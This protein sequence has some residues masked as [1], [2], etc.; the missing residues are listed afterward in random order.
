MDPKLRVLV[1]DDTIVY[2]KIVSSVLAEMPN[3]EVVGT[4]ANG[5]IAL[6][7]IAQ[8]RPDLLLLDLEMPELGGLDV[9]R[10][11]KA[12][13]SPVG[14]IILSALTS[15]H[16]RITLDCLT[17]GAFDFI[18]KPA[19]GTFEENLQRVRA[20]LR[21]RVEAFARRRE[22]RR[23]LAGS[24]PPATPSTVSASAA[25][26][27]SSLAPSPPKALP[28]KAEAVAI[29]ISTGGPAALAEMLP[30]LPGD[31]DAAVLVVQHMPPVFT[32]S[33]AEDLDRRC[34]VRVSEA[35]D[36][37]PVKRGQV[38]IAPGGKQMKVCREGAGAVVRV[39]DDPP[40]NSCRPSA[41]YLFRSVAAAYGPR[42][43]GV[44]MTGMGN[45]GAAGCREIK[46]RGGWIVAQDEASCV[47]FG[48]PRQP[49]QE[50]IADAVLPLSQIADEVTRVVERCR[51][52]CK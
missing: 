12:E 2:R 28:T 11:L 19:N 48:M 35:Q 52:P 49:I 9:L 8:T 20:E 16:S 33:L 40:E 29:G 30:R 37:E 41:D 27:S 45:D 24:R 23:L 31:L 3:V 51:T 42:A 26:S 1:V 50:G 10:R 21:P 14:A 22:T 46:A 32:R 39:T 36:G 34:R 18:L 25:P 15:Q 17:L 43:M 44:I 38:L 7:K 47:V 4:A 6:E 13:G 5:K